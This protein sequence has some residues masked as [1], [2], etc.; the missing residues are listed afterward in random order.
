[1]SFPSLW[2]G[3]IFQDGLESLVN[4]SLN[5]A[6]TKRWEDPFMCKNL[7]TFMSNLFKTLQ[8]VKTQLLKTL[9]KRLTNEAINEHPVVTQMLKITLTNA[10]KPSFTTMRLIAYLLNFNSRAFPF[11]S[12]HK[13]KSY[14]LHKHGNNFNNIRKA[15]EIKRTRSFWCYSMH[16]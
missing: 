16:C 12:L 4:Q 1:M 3:E 10:D 14:I 13:R 6:L 8:F 11:S 2:L 5:Q 7:N 9:T 15:H